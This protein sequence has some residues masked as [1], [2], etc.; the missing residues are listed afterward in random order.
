MNLLRKYINW[1]LRESLVDDERSDEKKKGEDLLLEPDD[2]D[3][4]VDKSE[5]SVVANIA[6][7][8]TPLGTGPTYPL[9]SKKKRKN[10]A[11]IVGG[12]YEPYSTFK[13]KKK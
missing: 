6:G 7:V 12:G 9:K 2:I 4:P 11:E 5:V 10:P 1:V 3:D 13:K 8:S